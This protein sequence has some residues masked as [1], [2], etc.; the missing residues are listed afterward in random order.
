MITSGKW[1][2]FDPHFVRVTADALRLRFCVIAG[3]EEGRSP[4]S[5]ASAATP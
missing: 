4:P 5:K 2:V 1:L 3:R